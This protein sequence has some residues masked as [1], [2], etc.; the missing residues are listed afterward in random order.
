VLRHSTKGE[1]NRHFHNF[2]PHQHLSPFADL[3]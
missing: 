2:P 1:T 3:D